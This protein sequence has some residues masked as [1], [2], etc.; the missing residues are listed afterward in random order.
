MTTGR[1]QA[2]AGTDLSIHDAAVT[3]SVELLAGGAA[4]FYG[5]VSAPDITVTSGDINVAEGAQL[6]VW[7]VTDN[8]T[9]NAVTDR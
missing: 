6:G 3:N 2:A 5:T 9:F 7:G 1:F 8:L 4:N